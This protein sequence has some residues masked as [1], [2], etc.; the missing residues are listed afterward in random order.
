MNLFDA[1]S[2]AI[3]LSGLIPPP[4]QVTVTQ[5]ELSVLRALRTRHPVLMTNVEI[6]VAA[7]LSKVTVQSVVNR[8]I[9]KELAHRPEGPK[10]GATI[11]PLGIALLDRIPPLSQD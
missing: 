8:V 7:E 5:R 11:T 10:E 1:S 4:E 6:E 2:L 3:E 9:E